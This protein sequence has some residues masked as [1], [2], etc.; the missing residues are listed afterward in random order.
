MPE[1][2]ATKHLD[3]AESQLA[4]A[5]ELFGEGLKGIGSFNEVRAER[6]LQT[7]GL[8]LGIAT[9]KM[10]EAPFNALNNITD[11]DA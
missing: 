4:Q 6:L 5:E 8:H 1:Q 7:A 3:L 10:N 11:G 2:S 9:A